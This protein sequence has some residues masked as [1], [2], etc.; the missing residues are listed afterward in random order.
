MRSSSSRVQIFLATLCHF[1]DYNLAGIISPHHFNIHWS[2]LWPSVCHCSVSSKFGP[3]LCLYPSFTLQ[4]PGLNLP[5]V[6]RVRTRQHP[7]RGDTHP[8]ILIW[9]GAAALVTAR[10]SALTQTLSPSPVS[11]SQH[12]RRRQN[13]E[14]SLCNESGMKLFLMSRRLTFMN[15]LDRFDEGSI[16]EMF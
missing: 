9:H 11:P 10:A 15:I 1:S 2:L 14:F 5:R 13:T 8:F 7:S 16:V 4:P 12:C 3:I 6:T